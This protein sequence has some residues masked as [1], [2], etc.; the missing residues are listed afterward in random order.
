M[1][2]HNPLTNH[3]RIPLLPIDIKQG[4]DWRGIHNLVAGIGNVSKIAFPA[5]PTFDLVSRCESNVDHLPYG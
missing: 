5:V 4:G 3:A 1:P 2:H